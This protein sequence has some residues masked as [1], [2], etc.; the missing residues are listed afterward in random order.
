MAGENWGR[1]IVERELKATTVKNDDGSAP[2]MY[3]LRIGPPQNPQL[4]IECFQ[5]VD[6]AF[7]ETWNIGPA[8]GPLN[9][10]LKNN[11]TVV[12]SPAARIKTF[13][14]NV[15]PILQELEE[16]GIYNLLVDHHLKWHDASLFE[17][18]SALYI[19]HAYCYE[20]PGTGKVELGLPGIGGAVDGCGSAVGDWISHLLREPKYQDV[21]QKLERS[22]AT[23]KHAFVFVGFGGAPWEVEGYLMGEISEAPTQCPD[24]PFPVTGVWIVAET[25][26]NGVRW[27]GSAWHIFDAK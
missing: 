16:R 5:C 24:L 7:T 1:R 6:S 11:W 2:G 4:A 9:L 14:Q 15:E 18:L 25:A 23:E 21:L 17:R 26:K 22:G 10:A 13:K 12:I 8:R 27:D 3:D 19:D 20:M